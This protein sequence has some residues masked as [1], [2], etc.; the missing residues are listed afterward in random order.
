M[1]FTGAEGSGAW[2]GYVAGW[3]PVIWCLRRS[4]WCLGIWLLLADQRAAVAGLFGNCACGLHAAGAGG[5]YG[6]ELRGVA[7]LSMTYALTTI[8]AFGVV[9][10]VEESTGGD[11]CRILRGLASAPV[12]SFVYV[13]VHALACRDSAAGG[14]LW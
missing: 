9:A 11:S 12:L 10:A 8:G 4:R 5:A 1:G 2:R 7:L 14:I 6:A 3:V 13:G